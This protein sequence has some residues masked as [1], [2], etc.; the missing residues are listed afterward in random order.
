M[1]WSDLPFHPSIGTL[2][3]FAGLW[4]LF[5]GGSAVWRWVVHDEPSRGIVLALVSGVGLVGLIRPSLMRPLFVGWMVAAFPI[6]WVISRMMLLIV[7]YGV[8]T[9][10]GLVFRAMGRDVL[11]LKRLQSTS[12]WISKPSASTGRSYYRQF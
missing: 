12:Y 6:G 10:M 1:R 4:M 7:F 11:H 9:P 2:R 3:Q 5:F 8:F